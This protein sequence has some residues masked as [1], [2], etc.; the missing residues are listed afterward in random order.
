M[1]SVADGPASALQAVQLTADSTATDSSDVNATRP[2]RRSN[3]ISPHRTWTEPP[4]AISPGGRV[5]TPVMRQACRACCSLYPARGKSYHSPKRGH[6]APAA[7]RLPGMDIRDL[8]RPL[9]Q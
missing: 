9:H 5:D 3:L 4:V 7:C 2:R 6:L 8:P 1:V